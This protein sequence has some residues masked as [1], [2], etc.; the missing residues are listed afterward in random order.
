[1]VFTLRIVRALYDKFTALHEEAGKLLES[2]GDFWQCEMT[3][4]MAHIA[5][6]PPAPYSSLVPRSTPT[7]RSRGRPKG[8]K[9][10]DKDGRSPGRGRS[11]GR[12][13]V[14][15]MELKRDPQQKLCL[16]Q[17]RRWHKVYKI[18]WRI[19]LKRRLLP[20]GAASASVRHWRQ[21]DTTLHVLNTGAPGTPPEV[22][23][24]FA[25][26]IEKGI[27]PSTT[28][29]A[30]RRNSRTSGTN[31]GVP[32]GLSETRCCGYIHPNLP[33]PPCII[34]IIP[35]KKIEIVIIRRAI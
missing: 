33:S 35:N 19:S 27:L 18:S 31:Y 5:A 7:G 29:G 22:A 3:E 30:A 2:H 4:H 32:E 8:S 13:R 16:R 6:T 17:T 23:S 21:R 15:G 28:L 1:M 24:R 20:G 26:M 12:G 14:A 10:P 11:R 9:R 25:I 34:L